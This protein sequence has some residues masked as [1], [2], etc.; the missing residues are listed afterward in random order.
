MGCEPY[1]PSLLRAEAH[2]PAPLCLFSASLTSPCFPCNPSSQVAHEVVALEIMT[3]L[4][5]NA[6]DD[7]CGAA[8][9]AAPCTPRHAP[10]TRNG[11]RA[12][13]AFFVFFCY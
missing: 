3:L 9:H 11:R 2:T 5:E 13:G 7:R 12:P 4:L 8:P 10:F 6:T 1:C